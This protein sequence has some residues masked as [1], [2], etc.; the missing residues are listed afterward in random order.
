MCDNQAQIEFNLTSYLIELESKI[1][2]ESFGEHFCVL[3]PRS[4]SNEFLLQCHLLFHCHPGDI[5]TCSNC[6]KIFLTFWGYIKHF[7]ICSQTQKPSPTYISIIQPRSQNES[8][9]FDHVCPIC[10]SKFPDFR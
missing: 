8:A 10:L 1:K 2:M 7:C 9:V 6:T 3:C 5:Y 4:F